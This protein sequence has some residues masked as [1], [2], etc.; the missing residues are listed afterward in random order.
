M[1]GLRVC[2]PP[3]NGCCCKSILLN[4]MARPLQ[5]GQSTSAHASQRMRHDDAQLGV[6]IFGAI[7]DSGS[8]SRKSRL[9]VV[10]LAQPSIRHGQMRALKSQFPT[11]PRSHL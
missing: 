10:L 7:F 4:I 5:R 9:C 6:E 3:M 8:R 2:G 11:F 1:G